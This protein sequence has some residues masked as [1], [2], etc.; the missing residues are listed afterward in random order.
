M[1]ECNRCLITTAI[2]GIRIDNE[3]EF[4]KIHDKLELES[5]TFNL[6]GFISKLKRAKNKYHCLIGISG[7]LDSSFMLEYTVRTLKL[8]PLVIHFDNGWNTE[9]ADR[10]MLTLVNALNVDFIRYHINRNLY[11]EV[12]K[13]LLLAGVPDADI[14]N[15]MVMAEL[16][17]RTAR[18]YNIEYIFNGHDF[19]HEGSS[20]LAWTY[21]DARY[22]KSVYKRWIGKELKDFP[23]I[24]FWQQMFQR[25]KQFR[26]LYY[27]DYNPGKEKSRLIATYGW[28][29]YGEKH[30]ENIYTWFIGAYLLP[31]KFGIDKRITYLSARI[32]SGEIS[33]KEGLRIISTPVIYDGDTFIM[34]RFNLSWLTVMNAPIDDHYSYKTYHSMF[35]KYRWIMW[36]L[37]KL[38]V[39]P[40][41]FYKKYCSN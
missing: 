16:M 15:D 14:T 39:V 34:K 7:G 20:P 11:N 22:V 13:S 37:M 19:R 30:S 35:I 29:D 38:S 8:N 2:P 40:Y 18:Q 26:L 25:T 31:V 5:W 27:V 41:L 17:V 10:N 36:V 9:I 32:R 6:D 4:C 28:E 3:C 12:C 23:M 1:K 24:G 33:K 21:M